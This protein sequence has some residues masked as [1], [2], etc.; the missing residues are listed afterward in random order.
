MNLAD[1]I[2][3][4]LP[5]LRR[6]ARALTGSQEA[7]D[8]YVVATME[9]IVADPG[10][11]PTDVGPRVGLYRIF[12]KIWGSFD[13]NEKADRV[14]GGLATGANRTL[15]A[16]TPRPRQALLLTSLERF[17]NADAAAA[18]EINADEI[19]AL[20]QAAGAEV[21]V[22]VR[23]RVL[24][25]EDEPLIAEDLRTLVK[26]LGHDVVGMAR[27][28]TQAVEIA[29]K[30][31]PGLVLADIQLADGSSGIDAVNDLLGSFEFPV[32]FIT[33]YPDRLLTGKRPEPTFLITKPFEDETVKA[34]IS[35]ALF[36]NN[37]AKSG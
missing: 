29:T 27:T 6:Y 36:F 22:Q 18:M 5:Y 10:G 35:Q 23:T 24:I 2:S 34:V 16:I 21:A 31:K 33:A 15:Q 30:E 1:S 9:A 3:P 12:L 17:S 4:E 28:R 19:R 20:I 7:G 25:I 13:I 8:A 32:I 37:A 26:A 14:E 11:F